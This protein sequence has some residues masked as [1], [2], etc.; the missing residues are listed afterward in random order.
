MQDPEN[1]LYSC[2]DL[3]AFHVYWSGSILNWSNNFSM[4]SS[5]LCFSVFISTVSLLNVMN[6]KSVIMWSGVWSRLNGKTMLGMIV[7]LFYDLHW[8]LMIREKLQLALLRICKRFSQTG[9]IQNP[10]FLSQKPSWGTKPYDHSYNMLV[11]SC[12]VMPLFVLSDHIFLFFISMWLVRHMRHYRYL[13]GFLTNLLA[14]G[15]F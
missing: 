7:L 5:L 1:I 10:K 11:W 2:S 3:S 12:P 4:V 6:Q 15:E 13:F 14:S 9:L 8:V